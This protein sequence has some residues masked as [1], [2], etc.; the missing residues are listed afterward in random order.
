MSVMPIPL[1]CA[2]HAMELGGSHTLKTTATQS[3]ARADRG[4]T[5]GVCL[6]VR[7]YVARLIVINFKSL[8]LCDLTVTYRRLG[9]LLV[10]TMAGIN[11]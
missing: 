4:Q 10:F 7:T 3:A 6:C 9:V 8:F 1:V 5:S 11:K 2:V